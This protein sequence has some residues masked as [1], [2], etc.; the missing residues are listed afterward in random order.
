M[1]FF[2]LSC[3]KS[4]ESYINKRATHTAD[5]IKNQNLDI[6]K[7]PE[8][9][10]MLTKEQVEKIDGLLRER[11]ALFSK[12]RNKE[13]DI[14]SFVRKVYYINADLKKTPIS[15][16]DMQIPKE[17]EL[18][19]NEYLK[20]KKEARVAKLTDLIDKRAALIDE[21]KKESELS[22]SN[23]TSRIR[24][25]EEKIRELS[26]TQE[27]ASNP[28]KLESL[29]LLQNY[30]WTKYAHINW[31][32]SLDLEWILENEDVRKTL[33]KVINNSVFNFSRRSTL[34]E[35]YLDQFISKFSDL[36][37]ADQFVSILERVFPKVSIEKI[38]EHLSPK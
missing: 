2:V 15:Q 17:I 27:E 12:Y 26:P 29:L 8:D 37:E 25:I 9:K 4:N 24:K 34:S 36:F 16:K 35:E 38:I 33:K 6:N 18:A 19:I 30:S 22:L 3:N 7:V 20:S 10:K 5:N 14:E 31:V 23:M 28:D 32:F 13:I 11:E 1:L 21:F